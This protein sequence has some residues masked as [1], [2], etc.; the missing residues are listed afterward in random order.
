M[1]P[2]AARARARAILLLDAV[3]G[4]P[5]G[6]WSR[7]D[8]RTLP[9]LR[10]GGGGDAARH[11]QA[12]SSSTP[13]RD[14][15]RFLDAVQNA[16]LVADAE[17]YYR[18]MYYGASESWNQRDRHMFDTLERLLA[19]PWARRRRR[20]CGRTTRTSATRAATEMGGRGELNLGQLCRRAIRRGG[21]PDRLRHRPR[22][23]RRRARLGRADAR[24]DASARRIPRA[25]SGC[26]TSRASGAFFLHLREPAREE[27]R[28]ELEPPRL[29]R[30]VGVVY[31]PETELQSHYFHASPAAPVRRVHLVRRDAG[32]PADHGRARRR[33]SPRS[34]RSRPSRADAARGRGD[35]EETRVD[36]RA[37]GSGRTG[38]A[39]SGRMRSAWCCSSRWA[40]SWGT[41]GTSTRRSGSWRRWSACSAARAASGS[42]RRPTAM[43]S[44][45]TTSRCGCLRCMS[46]PRSGPCTTSAPS[47]WSARSIRGS[48][49]PASA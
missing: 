3:G 28:A 29:E 49:G 2:P 14:G 23:G 1:D 33:R 21:L 43:G 17:R 8:Q 22:N 10:E 24:H 36:A 32:G 25:T 18:A 12:A 20:S 34:I 27:V 47:R 39:T 38:P 9:R 31:R 41:V 16:R 35:A 5:A 40:R 13:E 48:S 11:A 46:S 15:E 37:S 45:S 4:R 7:R 42:A 6:L 30:A 19:L 26:A 44:T